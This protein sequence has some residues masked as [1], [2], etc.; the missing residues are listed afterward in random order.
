MAAVILEL[1]EL[2]KAPEWNGT[3]F[4][5]TLSG[6][7]KL[8][9]QEC[10]MGTLS[11]PSEVNSLTQVCISGIFVVPLESAIDTESIG[12]TFD[13]LY[14][15]AGNMYRTVWYQSAS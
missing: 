14:P 10:T 13:P 12:V 5:A 2:P 11:S 15:Y 9:L 8:V 3:F 4:A 1:L 7:K 6:R